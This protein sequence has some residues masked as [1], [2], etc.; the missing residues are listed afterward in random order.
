MKLAVIGCGYVGLVS[1]SCLAEAG[2]EVI[3]TDNDASKIATLQAGKIPIYEPNL[4]KVL[5]TVVREGRL[6][7]TANGGEAVRESDVVF[8]CVGTPPTDSGDADL[9]AI[10]SVARMIA[11]ESRTPKLV[12]EKSTVP[13][14]TGEQLKRALQV[15]A[16]NAGAKFR[17]ASNPEFLREGTAVEDFFHPD[18]IVIGV[19]DKDAS[20]KCGKSTRRFSRA[21]SVARCTCRIARP[22]PRPI[23]WS[24]PLPARN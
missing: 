18:R 3:A 24:P 22:R 15:Y 13:A 6:R 19:E 21:G 2:H 4:D 11:R 16:S 8:I 20:G 14:Q 5:E 1:G 17:V 9:S 10:D 23:S 7:F 12:I